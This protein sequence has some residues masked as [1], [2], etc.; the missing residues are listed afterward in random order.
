MKRILVIDP[1]QMPPPSATLEF[2]IKAWCA[3]GVS[4]PPSKRHDFGLEFEQRDD[5]HF[6]SL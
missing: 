1:H 4:R 3:G 2:N 6:V 5:G